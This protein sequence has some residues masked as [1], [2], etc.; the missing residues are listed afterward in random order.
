VIHYRR[1][2]NDDPP[3]VVRL[4][5]TALAGPRAVPLP[6]HGATLL[7]YFLFSKPYFDPD[8]L[9]LACDER[10][11][12]GLVHAGFAGRPGAEGVDTT[13]GVICALGVAPEHRHKGVGREL[14]RRAEEYLRDRGATT[15]LAGPMAPAN[16][17]TFALYGGA[18]S[19]GFLESHVAA[20]PFFEKHG[21][22]IERSCGIFR[23]ALEKATIPND[24]RFAA[25][26]ARYEI[27]A[28][29]TSKAGWW[30]ESVLGPIEAVSY[31]LEDKA[32][33]ATDAEAVLWDMDLY[34]PC[35]G[36]SCVGLI[37][38][39]VAPQQRRQGL[40]KY[41]LSQVLRHL[42]DQPFHLFE[43]RAGLDDPAALG[44]LRSLQ[45]DQVEVGHCYRREG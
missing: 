9:I 18:D 32:T 11:G 10:D 16:P 7:E 3:R 15:I 27:I 22:R 19:A 35:W 30:R 1:F 37:D 12:V 38:L 36:V 5:N 23:R 21:Y 26:R 43:A 31:R 33:R 24:A 17:F 41:L 29:P 34:F 42:R 4:W 44:L 25:L 28:A 2:R 6:G 40:A 45:F 8:G 39:V 13:T 14:L 20:R